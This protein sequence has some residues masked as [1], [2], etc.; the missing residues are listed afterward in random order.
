MKVV[1]VVHPQ[2][3]ALKLDLRGLEVE[4]PLIRIVQSLL[5]ARRDALGTTPVSRF[6]GRAELN[7]GQEFSGTLSKIEFREIHNCPRYVS[8]YIH[9]LSDSSVDHFAVAELALA[10]L[11][12]ER[13][14]TFFERMKRESERSNHVLPFGDLVELSDQLMYFQC[15]LPWKLTGKRFAHAE[16]FKLSL[17]YEFHQRIQTIPDA[18]FVN[19]SELLRDLKAG[20]PANVDIKSRGERDDEM[21]APPEE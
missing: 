9:A 21:R 8:A 3:P 17:T 14:G 15:P 19:F 10:I 16:R 2:S 18:P 12:K 5:E 6:E 1:A 13:V 20:C 4:R 11:S 7:R